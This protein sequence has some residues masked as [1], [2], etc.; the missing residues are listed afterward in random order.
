MKVLI[1]GSGGREHALAWKCAQDD[2]VKHVFVCPGNAGT[3]LEDK[4]SNVEL[5]LNEF[6]SIEKFCLEEKVELV[7]IGPEQPL[8]DGLTDFLQS[9][10]I[11]T[12]GPSKNAAQLEGSKTFSKD[13]FVKYN[14]PTAKY[15][16]FD[17][18][19][20]SLEYLN[21][22]SFPTVVKADGLAA[23]KGVIICQNSEE[24]IKALDSIFNDKAFGTAGNRVVIEEFL[25]GEE[26]S[27]IAV[28][29]KD[30]II[31]LA[32]SQDHK[33][34]GDGDVGLNTGGMG[35]YSPAPIVTEEIH[36]KILNEVMYPT[37]NG[38]INEG[39]PYLGFLYA[40][41][42]IKDN[43]IKVLEFNCRFG[44]PETQPILLRLNSSLVELCKAAIDD[45]LDTYSIQWTEKHSCGVVIA[46]EGYPEDYESNKKVSIK[47]NNIKDSKLFHAG[48]KYE[49]EMVLTSGGRVFCA[50]A[51]GSDLKDAQKNAYNLVNNVEFDGAF[52]RK[53]IGFKGI[54]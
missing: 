41:L 17:N 16:S 15:K 21:E 46:S 35:A 36:K 43:E 22:I 19:E 32:T 49:N 14:I 45:E 40:G 2:I 7:I 51:L 1:I 47:E 20:S 42:M 5:N 27:F 28:V 25:E 44:D 30:K 52:F 24:A 50:T 10:N 48:T 6:S 26:A 8:V 31:P 13:F 39:S 29:S 9:K 54:K 23:G 37:M 53:D 33:A 18:F 3:Y 11:K 4:V 34:V 38:L 12:F